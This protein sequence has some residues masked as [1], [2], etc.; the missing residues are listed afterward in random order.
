[1]KN[2]KVWFLSSVILTSVTLP[3]VSNAEADLCLLDKIALTTVTIVLAPVFVPM[4]AIGDQIKEQRSEDQAYKYLLE[5]KKAVLSAAMECTNDSKVMI[6]L[7][8][9]GV[10]SAHKD[11]YPDYSQFVVK[12]DLSSGKFNADDMRI[13]NHLRNLND[14]VVDFGFTEKEV[15]Q[16]KEKAIQTRNSCEQ[17]KTNDI[18]VSD[19]KEVK[20]QGLEASK[21]EVM[22]NNIS[23]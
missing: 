6:K 8:L 10:Y 14:F 2:F 19:N 23:R 13:N 9:S 11:Y 5:D 17:V 7:P 21:V 16:L 18:A 4:F 3:S 1:M 12:F 22:A 15:A 20:S